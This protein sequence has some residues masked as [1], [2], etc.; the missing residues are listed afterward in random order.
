MFVSSRRGLLACLDP[1]A[2]GCQ[3]VR[4]REGKKVCAWGKPDSQGPLN[5]KETSIR[6]PAR[7]ELA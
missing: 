4:T 2:R 6:N 1:W 5:T 7:G 3:M